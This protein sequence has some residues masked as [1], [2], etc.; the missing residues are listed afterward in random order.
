MV[1]RISLISLIS[2]ERVFREGFRERKGSE[3]GS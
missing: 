2:G 1:V 3:K